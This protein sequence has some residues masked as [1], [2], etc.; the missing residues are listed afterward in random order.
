MHIN[1]LKIIVITALNNASS[2]T[3]RNQDPRFIYC[4]LNC[5]SPYSSGAIVGALARIPV[6]GSLVIAHYDRSFMLEVVVIIICCNSL[7]LQPKACT[8]YKRA[9]NVNPYTLYM[10]SM[11]HN[12]PS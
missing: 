3:S 1:R 7:D 6:L 10:S 12:C 5:W 9:Y 4:K 2:L 8:L 11:V